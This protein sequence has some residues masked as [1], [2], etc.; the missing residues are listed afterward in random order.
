MRTNIFS[1]CGVK[2]TPMRTC[3]DWLDVVLGVR[4]DQQFAADIVKQLVVA[5]AALVKHRQGDGLVGM[6]RREGGEKDLAGL[7]AGGL[8]LDHQPLS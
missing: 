1:N 4:E 5:R 6:G 8:G 7:M 3:L 2:T